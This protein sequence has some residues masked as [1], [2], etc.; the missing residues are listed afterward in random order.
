M[1]PLKPEF[2]FNVNENL[3]NEI[4]KFKSWTMAFS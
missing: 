2:T 3:R 1:E 4:I